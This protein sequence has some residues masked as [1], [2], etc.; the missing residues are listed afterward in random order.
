MMR[1]RLLITVVETPEFL[2]A[3]KKLFTEIQRADLVDYLARMPEDGDLIPDSGGIR[4]LRWMLEGRGK[5]GGARV[6]Y[7]YHDHRLPLF[8]LTAYAKNQKDDLDAGIL[9]DFRALTKFIA[10]TYAAKGRRKLQ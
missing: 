2:S 6:I 8:L 1:R 5:R 10:A 9:K 7:F 3:T 4:K